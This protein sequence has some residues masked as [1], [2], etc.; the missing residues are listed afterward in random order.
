MEVANC[1]LWVEFEFC[2][3]CAEKT[4]A[5][6]VSA[7]LVVVGVEG[8]LDRWVISCGLG[9]GEATAGLVDRKEEGKGKVKVRC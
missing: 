8:C 5:G 7:E 2:E 6:L 4:E 3:L 1:E 9:R